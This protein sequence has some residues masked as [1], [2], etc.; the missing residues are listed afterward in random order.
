MLHYMRNK[1]IDI[2]VKMLLQDLQDHPVGTLTK[3]QEDG[4]LSQMWENPVFR[5]RVANRDARIIFTMAGGE[6]LQPEPRE[7][8][9]L[10]AGQRVENLLWARDAKAAYERIQKLKQVVN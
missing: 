10:H 1:I 9:A 7:T 8:Y 5:K 6:G 4:M 3:E 2:L